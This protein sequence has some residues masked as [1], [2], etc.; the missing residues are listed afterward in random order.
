MAAQRLRGL[1][2]VEGETLAEGDEAVQEARREEE[3]VV[4]GEDPIEVERRGSRA[5]SGGSAASTAPSA[6][7]TSWRSEPTG[8]SAAASSDPGRYTL[9]TTTRRAGCVPARRSTRRRVST[10]RS[11]AENATSPTERF[12]S[13]QGWV[14]SPASPENRSVVIASLSAVP[15]AGAPPPP[16]DPPSGR[17]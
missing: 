13:R 4:D 7:V 5:A 11:I 2:Q 10:A 3:V 17:P 6:N 16:R 15:V 8:G 9:A 12:T 14:T 1:G